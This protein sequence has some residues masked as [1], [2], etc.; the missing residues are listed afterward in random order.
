MEFKSANDD[1]EFIQDWTSETVGDPINTSTWTVDAGITKGT[2]E[3]TDSNTTLW[4]SGGVSGQTYKVIN[5]IVTDA[6]RDF[7]REWYL[8]IQDQRAS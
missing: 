3:Q 4:V 7:S 5:R 2:E 6:G 8:R 1:Y